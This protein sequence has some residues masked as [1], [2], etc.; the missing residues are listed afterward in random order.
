[1]VRADLQSNCPNISLSG[2]YISSFNINLQSILKLSGPALTEE[3]HSEPGCEISVTASYKYSWSFT[4]FCPNISRFGFASVPISL[5]IPP[6]W[7]DT[8]DWLQMVEDWN[9]FK[10]TSISTEISP[11]LIC[12]F[13]FGPTYGGRGMF[14]S[15][16]ITTKY[17]LAGFPDYL[18]QP[19]LEF[20]PV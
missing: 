4:S 13:W 15:T 12:I 1:M 18:H 5:F 8:V 2:L 17:Q 10:L 6:Q 9:T 14:S 16:V 3:R 11:D 7:L 20:S 19:K